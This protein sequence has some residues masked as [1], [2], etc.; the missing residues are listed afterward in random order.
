MAAAVGWTR[1]ELAELWNELPL[2][3]AELAGRLGIQAG[4]LNTQLCR[5]VEQLNRLVLD[6]AEPGNGP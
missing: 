4:A 6:P 2:P 3:R 1:A 5:A